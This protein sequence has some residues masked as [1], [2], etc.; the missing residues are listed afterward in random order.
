MFALDAFSP[1]HSFWKN[2]ADFLMHLMP[3]FVLLAILIVACKWE[4]TGGIILTIVGLAWS[5]FVF[6]LN[7]RRTH[8]LMYSINVILMVG[9]PFVI[10]GILFIIS[11][12][13]KRKELPGVQ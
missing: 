7:F 11:Y 8:L 9:I 6:Q 2:I 10:A 12:Y 5:L 1:E 3:S 4:K 13:R